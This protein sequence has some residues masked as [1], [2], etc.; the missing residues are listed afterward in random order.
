MSLIGF[1]VMQK[2]RVAI[3]EQMSLS[4]RATGRALPPDKRTGGAQIDLIQDPRVDA[5]HRRRRHA[6]RQ[7]RQLV[8]DTVHALNEEG[9][10]YSEIARS[11]GYGRRSIA[12]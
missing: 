6:H 7:S 12:K 4:G 8:F 9:L 2:L 10:S 11:T 1:H 5:R 3:E